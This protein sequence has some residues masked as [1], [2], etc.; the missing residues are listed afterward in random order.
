MIV[1]FAASLVAAV[2]F[3]VSIVSPSSWLLA[4]CCCSPSPGLPRVMALGSLFDG[5]DKAIKKERRDRA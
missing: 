4:G 5:H 3:V 1:T 2:T